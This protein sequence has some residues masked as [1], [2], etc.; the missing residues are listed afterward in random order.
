MFDPYQA[1]ANDK[2]GDAQRAEEMAKIMEDMPPDPTDLRYI[3]GN[4]GFDDESS[5]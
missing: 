1:I 2:K 4:G 3:M 5:I